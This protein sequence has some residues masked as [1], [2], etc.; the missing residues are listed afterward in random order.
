[1]FDREG[2]GYI[3]GKELRHALLNLGEKLTEE[4]VDDL[5]KEAGVDTDGQLNYSSK[6]GSIG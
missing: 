5:M 1:M 3:D 4:E 6:S 2:S